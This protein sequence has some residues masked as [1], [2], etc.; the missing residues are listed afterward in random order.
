[1][2]VRCSPGLRRTWR[3]THHPLPCCRRRTARHLP[4]PRCHR[5]EQHMRRRRRPHP[6]PHTPRRS[7]IRRCP[8]LAV[9]Q[10]RRSPCPSRRRPRQYPGLRR[11]CRPPRFP[12]IRHRISAGI[13]R[14][15]SRCRLA[16]KYP[17]LPRPESASMCRH[18]RYPESRY[19]A[20]CRR[21]RLLRP[22][23]AVAHP[24]RR[25]ARTNT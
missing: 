19:P 2:T 7:C 10:S 16:P 9:R 5:F 6:R 25:C 15:H 12:A 1:M 13:R 20:R 14:R 22:H 3:R 21:R 4:P 18:R 8:H 23:P 17:E 11:W 24:R